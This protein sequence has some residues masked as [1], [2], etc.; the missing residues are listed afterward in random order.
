MAILCPADIIM[1]KRKKTLRVRETA[2][3]RRPSESQLSVA[4]QL[5]PCQSGSNARI[6]LFTQPYLIPNPICYR[7]FLSCLLANTHQK[8]QTSKASD[9]QPS[10]L[11]SLLFFSLAAKRISSPSFLASF[12][13]LSAAPL[14]WS[15]N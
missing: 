15:L 14:T 9:L 10:L 5:Y 2:I 1:V 6:S 12:L 3:Q 7:T 11:S 13:A 4:S 8:A